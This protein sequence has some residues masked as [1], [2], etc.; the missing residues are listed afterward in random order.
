MKERFARLCL[1]SD[2]T[3]SSKRCTLARVVQCTVIAHHHANF[4]AANFPEEMEEREN[5]GQSV[6]VPKMHLRG[7]TAAEFDAWP[8]RGRRKGT[9]VVRLA[10]KT[11]T[12]PK[13]PHPFSSAHSHVETIHDS[14]SCIPISDI[15][16]APPDHL[17]AC[18]EATDG[19]R[20]DSG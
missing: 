19:D 13:Q 3:R 2:G 8:R 12:S 1:V 9:E 5:Q 14:C 6:R 7:Q 18:H 10:G 16:A 20:N 17:A 4:L 15:I 11:G